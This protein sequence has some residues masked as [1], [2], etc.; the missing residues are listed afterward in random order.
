[1]LFNVVAPRFGAALEHLDIVKA[2][3]AILRCQ[4]G[5]G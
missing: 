2:L 4:T 1:V 3:F 5:S